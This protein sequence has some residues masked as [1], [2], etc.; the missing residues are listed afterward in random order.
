MAGSAL[1]YSSYLGGNLDELG[2]GIAV[3][4]L[5]N[6]Y[7]AGT[8]TSSDFPTTPDAFLVLGCCG[9][10]LF[11]DAFVTKLNTSGSALLYSTYLLRWK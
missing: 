2:S 11:Q 8:T 6:A 1:V 4:A 3:D 9:G 5:G 7:V 10:N